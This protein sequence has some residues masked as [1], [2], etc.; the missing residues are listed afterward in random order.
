MADSNIEQLL[1]QILGTK[2]GKDMRQAIH[3]G[4]EQCY[5]DGK[6]GAVDLVARQR[7]DNLAKLQ[8]GSTTGDAE[9][10]DIRVGADGKVY[11]SAGEAVRGQF[12]NSVSFDHYIG[13]ANSDTY[14]GNVKKIGDLNPHKSYLIWHNAYSTFSDIDE[15]IKEY[16]GNT[17]ISYFIIGAALWCMPETEQ[18]VNTTYTIPVILYTAKNSVLVCMYT[19]AT[20]KNKKLIL[21]YVIPRLDPTLSI[22][23]RAADAKAVGD[24]FANSVSFDH[25]IGKANSDTYAGNVKKIGDLNPHKSYL[26]WHN[27]YSTFS[28]IDESIKEYLG[29]T[30]ISYF[31]IGA[32]LWCMPETEQYVNTTYTIPVILYTA[33]NS[34]LVCMYTGATDKNKKLI[35]KY[36]IP[37]LDPTLSIEGRAA[38]AKAVGD[39]FS[40]LNDRVGDTT[41]TN[42]ISPDGS[43]WTIQVS[44]SG[45]IISIP[46]IPNNAL[47]IGNSIL[48]GFGEF[49]MAAS[50]AEHDYYHYISSLN[51]K[52]SYARLSGSG[53]E[54][55]TST[56]IATQ[57]MNDV[58]LPEL[59]N[60]L[61]L[62]IVQLG[63]NV[64]TEEK[65]RTFSETCKMILEFIRTH[66]PNARVVWV[67]SWYAKELK[68]TYEKACKE[69]GCMYVDITDITGANKIGGIYTVSQSTSTDY[70]V[71]SFEVLEGKQ[72]KIYFTVGG[73]QY[74]ATVHY[75]SYSSNAGVS[76]TIVGKEKVITSSGIAS[77]PG[78]N[79]MLSIANRIAYKLGMIAQEGDIK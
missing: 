61:D 18:Y 10:M 7:I 60:E 40:D 39:M 27:A 1:K 57:W 35:L 14:A 16:L 42:L 65:R 13:K 71:D 68:T 9:L 19:G 78:N 25:Y 62:V 32:A 74:D 55:S 17:T 33:K 59:N 52:G 6:V 67:G 58:L 24:M 50:D 69:T 72:I 77:H 73:N 12:A 56:R 38:D 76:V 64:N 31:I 53:F 20:D 2:L 63:D 23:G 46:V 28:D 70:S 5:E 47:F 66:A 37:R 22:E 29:N 51:P 34:V 4:I 75:D 79:G 3:D 49:G 41:L 8:E 44:N 26:I 15:S 11:E 30:T 48:L 45:A 36:V 54:G 21:K 43:K